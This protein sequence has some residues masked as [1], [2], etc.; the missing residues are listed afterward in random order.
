MSQFADRPFAVGSMFGIRSFRVTSDGTLTG[1]VHQG[2]WHGG[3]NE[4]VCN[5]PARMF[6]AVANAGVSLAQMSWAFAKTNADGNGKVLL[7]KR[8]KDPTPPPHTIGEMGCTCGYYAY[9][10]NGYNPHHC[11]GNALGII[12]GFGVMTVGTRG[13]RCS[14]AR[15]RALITDLS[16]AGPVRPGPQYDHIPRF[17]TIE[18]AL[19]EFPLTVPEGTPEPTDEQ[20]STHVGPHSVTY[21][22]T[23]DTRG[24]SALFQQ[25][26][27]QFGRTPTR[28]F[29]S[30]A[31]AADSQ[32]TPYE[33]ALRLRRERNT[34]PADP[35]GLDGRKRGRRA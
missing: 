30:T 28:Q 10:Y 2:E 35:R 24:L 22:L 20:F 26:A 6:A 1:V 9:F 4:G 17:T 3:I 8:P 29:G 14:K 16:T 5:S 23:V 12:E 18:E 27:R 21:T 13:F 19:A 34:G 25:M 33:R 32:E 15:I 11:Q 31:Q 7:K